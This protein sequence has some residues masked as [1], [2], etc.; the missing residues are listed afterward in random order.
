MAQDISNIGT[1]FTHEYL[2][3]DPQC[4][5]VLLEEFTSA[6]PMAGNF[7][8]YITNTAQYGGMDI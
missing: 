8:D 3:Y 5:I 6:L 2:L 4:F 7:A 1:I